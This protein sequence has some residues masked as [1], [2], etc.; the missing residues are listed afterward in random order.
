MFKSFMIIMGSLE[1]FWKSPSVYTL[2]LWGICIFFL[3][4]WL[5]SN[6]LYKPLYKTPK[7]TLIMSMFDAALIVG[8]VVAFTDSMWCVVCGLRFGSMFP[9]D[10]WQIIASFLRDVVAMLLFLFFIH[11][12]FNLGILK[13]DQKTKILIV[14]NGVFLSAWFLTAISPAQ[15]DFTYA[16][17]HD[18]PFETIFRTFLVSHVIG[19]ILF[20]MLLWSFLRIEDSTITT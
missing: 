14:A 2:I 5:H 7:R 16:M 20:V 10:S 8:F 1:W 13:L 11:P 3:A 18:F 12:F 19:R 17:I 15:T 4:R 6:K 9:Q